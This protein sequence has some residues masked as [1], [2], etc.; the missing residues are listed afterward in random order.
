MSL[1]D[2]DIPLVLVS[3][4]KKQNIFE[5]LYENMH[6]TFFAGLAVL[7]VEV[8]DGLLQGV[9]VVL[10]GVL[11]ILLT[12]AYTY[13][14]TAFLVVLIVVS[15][16]VIGKELYNFRVD[17][18]KYLI[19]IED[20]DDLDE[21]VAI[22]DRM[23]PTLRDK[24]RTRVAQGKQLNNKSQ[25]YQRNKVLADESNDHVQEFYPMITVTMTWIRPI[26]AQLYLLSQQNQKMTDVPKIPCHYLSLLI[27]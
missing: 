10:V 18:N 27:Y 6:I 24:W 17:R 5:R 20:Q 19:E 7:P 22:E 23:K 3:K 21:L 4:Q 26:I 8:R 1:N 11:L 25:Y 14:L 15:V 16:L 13:N 2:T 9:A 12:L